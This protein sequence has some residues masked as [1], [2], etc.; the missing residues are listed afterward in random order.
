MKKKPEYKIIS[1]ENWI[2]CLYL[3]L[4]MQL[5]L[6]FLCSIC[7]SSSLVWIYLFWWWSSSSHDDYGSLFKTIRN[8]MF[9]SFFHPPPLMI[10]LICFAYF[11]PASCYAPS[12][13][14][15]YSFG[16]SCQR[17]LL[18]ICHYITMSLN[19]RELL[20]RQK[21]AILFSRS[22]FSLKMTMTMM[23][24]DEPL[25]R[26]H[27]TSVSGETGSIIVVISHSFESHA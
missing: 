16:L 9:F 3:S 4:V 7:S 13:S 10:C 21:Y 11:S 8:R 14:L 2:V 5:L 20:Q 23:I 27:M 18:I 6:L 17:T 25:I 12:L 19:Q 22:S 26:R 15:S 24:E 1:F